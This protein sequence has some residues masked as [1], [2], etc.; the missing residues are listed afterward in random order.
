VWS[1]R[2]YIRTDDFLANSVLFQCG[3]LAYNLL[4]WMAL[5]VGGTL[6]KWEVKSIRL[7]LIRIA[8]KLTS[9]SRRLTLKLPQNFLYQ[10]EWAA[11]DN[12]AQEIVFA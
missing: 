10:A 1:V 4:K 5:S 6:Q 9:G 11:W 7:W 8:G 3:V 12:M 2:Q